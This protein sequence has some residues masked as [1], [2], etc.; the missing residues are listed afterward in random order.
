MSK[1]TFTKID[2]NTFKWD[3]DSI[4]G[5]ILHKSYL[6]QEKKDL[7][8]QINPLQ[9]RLDEVNRLLDEIKKIEK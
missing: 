1:E 4:Q 7:L 9:E 8:E 6:M 2:S 5:D 3:R